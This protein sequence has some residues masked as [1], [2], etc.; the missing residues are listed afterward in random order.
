MF[1]FSRKDT[2]SGEITHS[3]EQEGTLSES[4]KKDWDKWGPYELITEEISLELAARAEVQLK[5]KEALARLR[6][7]DVKPVLTVPE[8]TEIV[9]DLVDLVKV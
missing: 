1:R 9:R 7:M 4:L 2:A 6:A 5:K 3:V 8:L